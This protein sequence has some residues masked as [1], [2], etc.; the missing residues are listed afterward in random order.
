M[1]DR[2]FKSLLGSTV[3]PRSRGM[4]QGGFRS[5]D[6]VPSLSQSV[7]TFLSGSFYNYLGKS[8]YG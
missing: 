8:K 7:L 5:M 3:L 4:Q 1:T 6:G 2:V